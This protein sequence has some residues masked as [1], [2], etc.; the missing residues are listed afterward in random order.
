MI[1]KSIPVEA[2]ILIQ[3]YHLYK[4][5]YTFM[6]HISK[7]CGFFYNYKLHSLYSLYHEP[8]QV[9]QEKNWTEKV[10]DE[11]KKFE[12]SIIMAMRVGFPILYHIFKIE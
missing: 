10:T 1:T 12:K 4:I 6:V 2:I 11:M 9:L 5:S 8:R 7:L 3:I